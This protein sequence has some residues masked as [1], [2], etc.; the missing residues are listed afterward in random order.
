MIINEDKIKAIKRH[1]ADDSFAS[2]DW[3]SY[4][5]RVSP[6]IIQQILKVENELEINPSSD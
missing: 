6:E 4:V 2:L 3:L 1:A 5:H